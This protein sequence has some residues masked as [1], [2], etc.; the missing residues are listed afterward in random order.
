MSQLGPVARMGPQVPPAHAAA[1]LVAV[2]AP[3]AGPSY[4]LAG[5]PHTP[6]PTL[7]PFPR[8]PVPLDPSPNTRPRKGGGGEDAG[9]LSGGNPVDLQGGSDRLRTESL[10]SPVPALA[11]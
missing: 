7:S 1:R 3:C 4:G 9:I 6:R 5:R 8:T 2:A 11:A 10:N